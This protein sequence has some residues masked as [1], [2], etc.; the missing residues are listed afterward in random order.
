MFWN[1]AAYCIIG[2]A[3]SVAI[4]KIIAFFSNPLRKCDGCGK[5]C[6]GCELEKLKKDIETK[7]KQ[8]K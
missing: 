4:Y 8:K 3:F 6:G 5:E 7:K 2:I 1:I